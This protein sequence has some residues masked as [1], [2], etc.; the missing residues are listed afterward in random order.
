MVVGTVHSGPQP[1]ESRVRSLTTG[2]SSLLMVFSFSLSMFRENLPSTWV[3]GERDLVCQI[4]AVV[5]RTPSIAACL[6]SSLPGAV[7]RPVP[8]VNDR[9]PIFFYC[10]APGS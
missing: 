4:D 3:A 1:S 9:D 8:R 7:L 6:R 2:T 5:D 10:I